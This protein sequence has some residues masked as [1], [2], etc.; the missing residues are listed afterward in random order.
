MK[1]VRL[2]VVHGAEHIP[3][4]WKGGP[5]DLVPVELEDIFIEYLGGG[6]IQ[7][8]M[9]AIVEDELDKMDDILMLLED[10]NPEPMDID[11]SQPEG[12]E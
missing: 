1:S 3:S 5:G 9:D 2:V 7:V 11:E 12:D 8:E 10:D 4:G 6:I